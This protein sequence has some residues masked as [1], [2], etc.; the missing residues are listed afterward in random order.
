MIR[1]R[2]IERRLCRVRPVSET[3]EEPTDK[4]RVLVVDDD[5]A[6]LMAVSRILARGGCDIVKCDDGRAALQA[7]EQ[8]D[9]DVAVLDVMLPHV[10]GLEILKEI[11]A[12]KPHLAVV[13]MTASGS[14]ETAVEAV[15]SGAF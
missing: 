1:W 11:R 13:M 14:I 9:L 15:K 7:V 4:P 5:P 12:K 3:I 2:P 10:T 6:V 8:D